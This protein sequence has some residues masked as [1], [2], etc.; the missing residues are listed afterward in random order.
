MAVTPVSNNGMGMGPGMAFAGEGP[1]L[2]GIWA[3]PS[4]GQ[5]IEIRDSMF[6]DGQL[7]AVTTDGHTLNYN[8]MQA[9]VQCRDRAE[10]EKLAGA[11]PLGNLHKKPE[12][13]PEVAGLVEGPA[14]EGLL[15]EDQALL[16]GMGQAD[17]EMRVQT[18]PK[19]PDYAIIERAIGGWRPEFSIVLEN[20]LPQGKIQALTTVLGIE[21][22]KIAK[23]LAENLDREMVMDMVREAITTELAIEESVEEMKEPVTARNIHQVKPV[24]MGGPKARA[25]AEKA[26][27][28]KWAAEDAAKEAAK[29]A[30]KKN[31]RKY[32]KE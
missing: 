6:E 10:A 7:I 4:T 32:S 2:T 14:D 22:K 21:A 18:V 11:K 25:A 8:Q 19:D 26:R 15:P 28:A 31:D 17:R 12:L 3:N 1:M 24:R 16:A 13:P 5:V 9:F 20:T 27:K 23:Y 30:E 29:E